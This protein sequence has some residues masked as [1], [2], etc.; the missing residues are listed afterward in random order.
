MTDLRCRVGWHHYEP[1]TSE[2]TRSGELVYDVPG[3]HLECSRCHHPK[4][5]HLDPA[6]ERHHSQSRDHTEGRP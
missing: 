5:V 3:L 6:D 2:R 4:L 1:R